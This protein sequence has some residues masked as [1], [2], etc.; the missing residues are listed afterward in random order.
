MFSSA[1][2]L[3]FPNNIFAETFLLEE[4]S[5]LPLDIWVNERE[6]GL[7]GG[8]NLQNF[9]ERNRIPPPI[10]H[11]RETLAGDFLKLLMQNMKMV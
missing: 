6:S 3:S 2:S 5:P 1:F 8:D 7:G 4:E 10:L 11:T 9:L